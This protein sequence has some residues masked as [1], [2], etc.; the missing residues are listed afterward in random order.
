MRTNHVLQSWRNGGQTIGVL[1][2]QNDVVARLIF[3]L[4][5]V[6]VPASEEGGNSL[7]D[8]VSVGIAFTTAL[9]WLDVSWSASATPR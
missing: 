9:G 8:A 7:T 1:V 6:G 3:E 5:R 4:R 2:R